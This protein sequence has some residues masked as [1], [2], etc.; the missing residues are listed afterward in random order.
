MKTD[1]L[2]LVAIVAVMAAV[3]GYLFF[4][5]DTQPGD[6]RD[7]PGAA[8]TANAGAGGGPRQTLGGEPTETFVLPADFKGRSPEDVATFF[9]RPR[10]EAYK[11][12]LAN[13]DSSQTKA[14]Q[15]VNVPTAW[16]AAYRQKLDEANPKGVGETPGANESTLANG[17]T[18]GTDESEPSAVPVQKNALPT[19]KNDAGDAPRT[20]APPIQ[21]AKRDNASAADKEAPWASF[22]HKVP[23]EQETT[24]PRPVPVP[25]SSR[26][27]SDPVRLSSKPTSGFA[28]EA[29]QGDTLWKIAETVYGKGTRYTDIVSANQALVGSDGSKLRAG[30]VIFI[31]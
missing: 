3:V 23:R 6:R 10:S 16:L 7:T 20:E 5:D 22:L 15:A 12:S 28:Y 1:R 11:Y 18:V 21:V 31:P 8:L 17:P 29:R 24:A 30:M 13:A 4:S 27:S 26:T 9:A 25:A 14:G 19:K 2:L